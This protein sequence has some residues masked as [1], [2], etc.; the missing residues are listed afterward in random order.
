MSTHNICFQG[1]IRK[2]IE[3]WVEKKVPYLELCSHTDW[4]RV[5]DFSVDFRVVFVSNT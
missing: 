4:A 2:N 3:I 5:T 1:E